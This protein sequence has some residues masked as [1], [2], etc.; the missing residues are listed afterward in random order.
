MPSS[1]YI[2]SA[3]RSADG[4]NA[5]LIGAAGVAGLVDV[6]VLDGTIHNDNSLVDND[7]RP[8]D[9]QGTVD[10][11]RPPLVGRAAEGDQ[12]SMAT[13]KTSGPCE[14]VPLSSSRS[15][16]VWLRAA[17]NTALSTLS[18]LISSAR[19]SMTTW[20]GIFVSWG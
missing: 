15:F 13:G 6:G 17:R 18:R 7:S 14:L 20:G 9:R 10:T 16:W 8:T 2:L 5:A 19:L 12:L 4:V 11:G 3:V 1:S